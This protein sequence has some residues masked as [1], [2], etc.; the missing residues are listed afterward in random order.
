MFDKRRSHH[1]VADL[2]AH[3]HGIVSASDLSRLGY[4]RANVSS[5]V[6]RGRLH[7]LHRGVY[8][9]GHTSVSRH[10]QCLAAVLACGEGSLLSHRSAA[11]LWGFTSRWQLPTEVTTPTPRRSRPR[12]AAHSARTLRAVD[13]DAREGIPVTAAPRTL[14]DFAAADPRFLTRALDGAERLGLLDIAA[15]DALLARNDRCRGSSRLRRALDIHRLPGFT[16]SGLERRFLGL[17]HDAG[18]PRPSMNFFMAGYELDAY[19]QA[20]RFAVE[21]DTYDYHGGH[22]AFEEDRLRQENLKLAGIEMTRI[23]G[24]RIEREPT[25]VAKRL[26]GLLAQR[27]RDL[28]NPVPR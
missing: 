4:S 5:E 10:G 13:R 16:R 20:E 14:L 8:A 3:Q 2:A 6:V 12:I 9:V 15:I 11:W 1:A 7:R 17:V 25:A 28:H 26:R 22:T 24:A 19:W 18:L 23:T 21:L 27:R